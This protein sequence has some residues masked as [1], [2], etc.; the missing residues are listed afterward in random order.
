MVWRHVTKGK[1]EKKGKQ[2]KK[3]KKPERHLVPVR[4]NRILPQRQRVGD[5]VPDDAL[6]WLPVVVL[7]LLRAASG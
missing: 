2:G 1:K 5:K 6:P 7:Q 4:I 3:E